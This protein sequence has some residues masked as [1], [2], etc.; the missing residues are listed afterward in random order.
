M[1]LGE[2]SRGSQLHPNIWVSCSKGEHIYILLSNFKKI[3]SPGGPVAKTPESHS[4]GSGF[5]PWSGN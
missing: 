1:G 5:N 4:R 3:S 2:W